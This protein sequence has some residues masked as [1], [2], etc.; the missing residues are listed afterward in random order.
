MARGMGPDGGRRHL[1]HSLGHQKKLV[2]APVVR[3]P[4]SI[5]D[6]PGRGVAEAQFAGLRRENAHPRV[7]ERQQIAQRHGGKVLQ[8]CSDFLVSHRQ[9]LGVPDGVAK[10]N[11]PLGGAAAV[12]VRERL[13]RLWPT[14]GQGLAG[15][16]RGGGRG[17]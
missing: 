11:E 5:Q 17:P 16:R 13:D 6:R 10:D 14:E 4:R 9:K 8:Q 1:R 3:D 15:R 12:V 7:L 2:E